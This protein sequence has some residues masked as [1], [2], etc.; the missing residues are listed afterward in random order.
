MM[1]FKVLYIAGVDIY[2]YYLHYETYLTMLW[3][4]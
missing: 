2:Q 4:F 1:K 3:A